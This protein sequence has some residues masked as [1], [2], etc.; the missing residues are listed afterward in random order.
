MRS[1]WKSSFLLELHHFDHLEPKNSSRY[2]AN[3]L[4]EVTKYL[5]TGLKNSLQTTYLDVNSLKNKRRH[6]YE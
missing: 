4:Y 2:L 1:D 3:N 6:G 5:E